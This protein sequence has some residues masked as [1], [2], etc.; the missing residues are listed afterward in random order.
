MNERTNWSH[1]RTGSRRLSTGP[2]GP[3]REE[4]R[5]GK[6]GETKSR[7]KEGDERHGVRR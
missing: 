4:E 1:V 6:R 7:G 5:R 3:E 2:S